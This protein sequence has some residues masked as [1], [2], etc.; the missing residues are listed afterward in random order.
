MLTSLISLAFPALLI[1]AMMKK[2]TQSPGQTGASKGLRSALI[3]KRLCR[4]S[5]KSLNSG[6]HAG[7]DPAS[8]NV[9]KALILHWIPGQADCKK[10]SIYIQ[11]Q[12]RNDK[13]V[14]YLYVRIVT[15]PLMEEG[16]TEGSGTSVRRILGP[17]TS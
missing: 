12:A 17:V 7:L 11:L 16:L 5:K 1:P 14:N 9:K 13:T 4:N 2:R 15:Q 6:C 10:L 3:I 8:R